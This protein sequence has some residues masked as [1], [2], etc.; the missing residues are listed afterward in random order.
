[1]MLPEKLTENTN[2]YFSL[3]TAAEFGIT[4]WQLQEL[5]HNG[6]IQKVSYGLYALKNVIPDELFITQLLSPR[7]IF[8]HESA[9]FFNGYSDQVPFRYTIS[10]PH[11][12]ISKNLSEQYDV[13]HVAKESA[14]EGIKIIKSELGN[15]LRVYSIE[16][17]L[18]ELL[19]KPSDLDKERFIPAIQKYLRSKNK[20]IL[21]LMHFAK[22]F[23]V[24][25]RLLPYLEAIQ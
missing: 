10:V 5:L 8:S 22:M 13:R 17:T 18:C 6:E 2:G 12:Y 21:I 23:R 20:D 24:E 9:L 3:K 14:E 16:R 1:M 11:G 25:K 15:D 4:R 7:A 19:H